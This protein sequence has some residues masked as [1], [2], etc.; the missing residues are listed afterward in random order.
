[1][2]NIFAQ[3]KSQL[4]GNGMANPEV[5]GITM[6][7]SFIIMDGDTVIDFDPENDIPEVEIEEDGQVFTQSLPDMVYLAEDKELG[8]RIKLDEHSKE[9]CEKYGFTNIIA[10]VVSARLLEGL[11]D[12]ELESD[13]GKIQE[14]FKKN[15]QYLSEINTFLEWTKIADY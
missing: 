5:G 9:L 6:L 14:Y 13:L 11:S 12:K 7:V 15:V 3:Y 10:E 4:L 8:Y 2:G 1:M